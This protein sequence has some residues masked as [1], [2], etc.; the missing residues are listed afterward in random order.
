ME[1]RLDLSETTIGF[2]VWS[3]WRIITSGWYP[4]AHYKPGQ[5]RGPLGLYKAR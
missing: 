3:F 4:T 5:N 1:L 2:A